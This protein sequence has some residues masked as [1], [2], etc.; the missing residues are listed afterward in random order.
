MSEWER[1]VATTIRDYMEHHAKRM[2]DNLR[3]YSMFV[4]P[5]EQERNTKAYAESTRIAKEIEDRKSPAQKLRERQAA[6]IHDFTKRKG[7]YVCRN[8][9][10]KPGASFVRGWREAWTN[11]YDAGVNSVDCDC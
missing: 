1:L 3:L 4:T 9:K 11:G 6:C 7:I 10:I 5:E 8:C 2:E